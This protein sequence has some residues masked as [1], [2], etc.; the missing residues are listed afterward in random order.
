MCL[1]PTS[2]IS[3]PWHG[4]LQGLEGNVLCQDYSKLIKGPCLQG[5][6]SKLHLSPES[7]S[8]HG[9]VSTRSFCINHTI[10][11][12]NRGQLS[13][14]CL[15]CICL[16]EHLLQVLNV[17]KRLMWQNWSPR[18]TSG[19]KLSRRNTITSLS[20]EYCSV[21]HHPDYQSSQWKLF[22][23]SLFGKRNK[24]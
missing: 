9:D 17:E 10:S 16:I 20:F 7:N 14:C 19:G 21:P 2:A 6:N 1:H 5:E 24:S 22:N 8:T 3:Q 15:D 23:N 12:V 18:F 4:F 11:Q 13:L